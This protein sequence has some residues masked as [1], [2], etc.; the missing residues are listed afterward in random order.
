MI[1]RVLVA[2]VALLST[3]LALA[4]DP[5]QLRIPDFSHLQSKAIESVDI[6]IAPFLLWLG[7]RIAQARAED[8]APVKEVM[9]GIK[10]VHVRSY[11]FDTDNA[12]SIDDIEKVRA[13][14]RSDLW[15]PLAEV[16]SRKSAENVDIFIALESDTPTGFAIVVT[17]PREFTIV[18]IVGTIDIEHLAQLQ[19]GL[20]LPGVGGKIATA[21]D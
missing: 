17:E 16:R 18:N 15:K 13:Q 5:A 11:Q 20:G 1:L 8:G 9:K 2:S 12:Y 14:L 19:A 21:H 7:S 3:S 4:Q 10:A 6:T